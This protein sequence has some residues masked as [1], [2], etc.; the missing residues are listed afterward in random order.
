MNRLDDFS[1]EEIMLILDNA[2]VHARKAAFKTLDIMENVMAHSERIDSDFEAT[3]A[4]RKRSAE[5]IQ[6]FETQLRNA[7]ERVR[8]RENITNS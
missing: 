8:D 3:Y 5:V 1:S 4:K 7:L 2:I 6:L